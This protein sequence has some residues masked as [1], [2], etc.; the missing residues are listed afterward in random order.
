LKII[1]GLLE[2]PFA[3]VQVHIDTDPRTAI[4]RGPQDLSI[5]GRVDRIKT[6]AAQHF[7][8]IQRPAFN[9][10]AIA[11]LAAD[12]IS[13]MVRDRQLHEVPGNSFVAQNRPR[14][15]DRRADVKILRLRIVSW[16]E[17][18][19]ARVLVV[20]AGRIHETTRTRWL[21]RLRQ[22]AD[23]KRPEIIRDC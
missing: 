19:T 18:E 3:R 1:H 2:S 13:Q 14:V 17:E 22:L 8:A 20:N 11:V 10:N 4:T 12:F 7:F 9:K 15:L 23:L 6:R 16:D 5:A 21:E